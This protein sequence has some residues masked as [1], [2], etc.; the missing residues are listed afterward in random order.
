MKLKYGSRVRVTDKVRNKDRLDKWGNHVDTLCSYG[1]RKQ[2]TFK[3]PPESEREDD[4]A[5]FSALNAWASCNLCRWPIFEPAS[6]ETNM[7]KTPQG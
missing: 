7:V 3:W 5:P 1:K 2:A 6:K 4:E